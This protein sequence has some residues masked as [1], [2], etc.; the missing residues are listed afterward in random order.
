MKKVKNVVIFGKYKNIVHDSTSIMNVAACKISNG[1]HNMSAS[2]D[3]TRVHVAA[4]PTQELE[5][6][7]RSALKF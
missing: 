5:F 1:V 7:A 2:E 6:R 3:S 4:G